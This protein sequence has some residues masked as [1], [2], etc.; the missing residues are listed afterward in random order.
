MTVHRIIPCICCEH[1]PSV[2]DG[3]EYGM[4]ILIPCNGLNPH[5]QFWEAKCPNC[6]RGGLFQYKSAYLALKHWNE[7]QSTLYSYENRKIEYREEWKDTCE[8]LGY[9]YIDWDE[10]FSESKEK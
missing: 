2:D 4:P 6:G 1:P 5:T 10:V 3:H 8:R 7:L 9:D